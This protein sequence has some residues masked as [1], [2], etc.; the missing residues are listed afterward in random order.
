VAHH[1]HCV[2]L[3][4]L[5]LRMT[6]K[7]V[8]GFRG[9]ASAL[10]F[11]S[12]FLGTDK[13]VVSPT[14][15]QMWLLRLG[16]Y[17]LSRAKEQADDWIWMVDH[18]IQVGKGKCFVVAGV[19]VAVLTAKRLDKYSSG[20]LTCQD[21][22][23]WEIELVE[24]SNGPTVEQQL[25]ALSETTGQVPCAILSD[26]GGDLS[27]GISQFCAT[28]PQTIALKDLPHFAAN[29]IK[30]E[31]SDDSQWTD[32]LADANRSKT[33]LRQSHFAFLL[34]PD[35]KSKARWMNLNPLINWSEKVLHFVNSPRAVPGMALEDEELQEKMGWL[36]KYRSSLRRWAEMLAVVNSTLKYIRKYG[37]HQNARNE[38][39]EILSPLAMPLNSHSRRV[40]DR[41]LD[42]VEEQSREIPEGEYLL[43][44]TEALESL[45]GKAKQLQGQQSRSGFTKMILG[46]AASVSQ[47]TADTIT[48]ALS[49]IKVRNVIEWV[50]NE[51]GPSVQAQ[52]IYALKASSNGTKIG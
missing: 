41:I 30:K 5:F 49:A 28:H 27:A 2:G 9:A 23:V 11:V 18:T 8:L 32:F 42:Y 36:L 4:L 20:A 13:L 38:L 51:I 7:G 24:K 34:P 50:A 26:C 45:L 6:L 35:L 15:G 47:L 33:E 1:S 40:A 39:N 14:G 48:T 44:T 25:T 17:E 16:L 37:Y 10:E 3:I 12:T 21:L 22:S 29:A 43:A 52:R 46:I 31:L 19:R